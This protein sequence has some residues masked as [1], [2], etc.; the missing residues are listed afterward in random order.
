MSEMTYRRLGAT[1]LKVSPLCLG[2][3]GRD[4]PHY[5]LVHRAEFEQELAKVCQTYR[6]G[7]IPYS[8]LAVSL[9]WLLARPG[10]TALIVGAN[11]VEQLRGSL[12]ALDLRLA[13]GIWRSW[14]GR[15]RGSARRCGP[16]LVCSQIKRSC[17]SSAL[18]RG[19]RVW[20]CRTSCRA[21]A[22]SVTKGETRFSIDWPKRKRRPAWARNRRRWARVMPT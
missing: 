1:G 13:L 4:R 19:R 12:A 16:N 5:N 2:S 8:P 17:R 10:M 20:V 21:A 22:M 14:T 11:T 6:L 3:I 15:R 9:A 18:G 7:V